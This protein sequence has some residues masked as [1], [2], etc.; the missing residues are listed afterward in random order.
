V[1]KRDSGRISRWGDKQKQT[2]TF[3]SNCGKQQVRQRY[4]VM[5]DGSQ[6]RWSTC[7]SCGFETYQRQV[8]APEHRM[9]RRSPFKNFGYHL[10]GVGSVPGPRILREME[11]AS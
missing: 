9:F 5:W 3:C 6:V 2:P 8:P 1:G 7:S 4:S 10:S 11:D